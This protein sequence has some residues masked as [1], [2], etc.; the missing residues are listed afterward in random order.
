VGVPGAQSRW[1][2]GGGLELQGGLIARVLGD[3]RAV[4]RAATQS[5]A[6]PIDLGDGLL[7]P[8]YVN[9]HAHLELS[10][11]SLQPAGF[12]AWIGEILKARRGLLPGDY[13]AAV[14]KGEESLLQSGTTCVGD[15]A[16]SAAAALG[17]RRLRTVVYREILDAWDPGRTAAVLAGIEEPLPVEEL[18]QEGLSPHAPYTVSEG[19]L[20]GASELLKRRPMPLSVHWA[21]CEAELDW[22]SRGT[23]DFAPFFPA[24]PGVSGL[25]LLERHGLLHA[26]TS[27]V[28]GNLPAAGELA[29][30]RAAG[31][32]LIHCPGTHAFFG[33]AAFAWDEYLRAGVPIALGTDSLAS[34]DA[35]GMGREMALARSSN[36]DL[37]P[38]QTL[39]MA[40]QLGAR[41]LGMA[42]EIGRIEVGAQADLCFHRALPEDPGAALEALT[43]GR[44]EVGQVFVAGRPMIQGIP[45][46]ASR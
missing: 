28:H 23:G 7:L 25:D 1:I 44:G 46:D 9:A 41:A 43:Q 35:L 11:L 8:G 31:S 14:L 22:M 33:R 29:R 38:M 21:E 19:L 42:Q 15:I 30:L 40:T 20:A 45:G 27:L 2:D 5:G 32:V 18:V 10:G 26:G 6:P 17:P 34:N 4:Q 37:S 36:P 39:G 13:R 3:V 12:A 16:S 24:S